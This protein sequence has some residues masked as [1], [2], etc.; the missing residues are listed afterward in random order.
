MQPKHPARV[1]MLAHTCYLTDPRVRRE[2]ETL[3][4]VGVEVHVISLAEE[5]RGVREGPE[6]VLNGVYIHRLNIDKR[7]G[8]FLR[9]L[10]EYS[11][12]GIL[13]GLK[14]AQ[15][16]LR[17]RLDVVHVHNMPD[18][19]V[20]AGLF[21]RLSGSK[22]VLDVHD[23]MPEL[24]MSWNDGARSLKVRLLRFQ[25]KISCWI[26]DWVISVNET[27]RENLRA[28]GV[29]DENIF[30]VH[31]FPDQNHFRVCD[32]PESWPRDPEQL[33]LL[34]CGTITEHYDLC[35]AVKAI[36]RLKGEIP[37]RLKLMGKGSRLAE[38]LNLASALGVRDSIELVGTVPI[39]NVAEEMRKADV[40]ISCH[41]AGI[42][43]DLYFSTKIVEYL[44]QGLAVLS[45]RTYTI[46]RYLSDDCLFYFKPGDDAALA[47]AIQFVWNNP[48]EVL[49][50]LREARKALSRLTWQ[51][52]K[53]RFCRFYAELLNDASVSAHTERLQMDAATTVGVLDSPERHKEARETALP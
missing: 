33:V 46:N 29:A 22:L 41:R 16:H 26:A 40:G 27:M 39:E 3:A 8:N 53:A 13:G 34:Y 32:T 5:W 11:M 50:R 45:P 15:L 20:L 7:R 52:E 35:L 19:L 17:R 47:D 30:I 28:K 38:V 44:T 6:S 48:N 25:E 18:L 49:K 31:N 4:D 23:P 51:T 9:Y 2:A 37:I 12:V 14:L 1:A 42:F 10:Y 24:Y 21:P 43:G 36:A